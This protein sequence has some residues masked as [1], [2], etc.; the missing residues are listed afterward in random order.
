MESNVSNGSEVLDKLANQN[1][2]SLSLLELVVNLIFAFVG[3]STTCLNALVII[4]FVKE[5]RIREAPG[6]VFILNLAISDSLTGIFVCYVAILNLCK[7]QNDEEYLFRMGFVGAF[8]LA[9]S[10]FLN[11]LTV[12]RYLKVTMHLRYLDLVTTRKHVILCAVTWMICIILGMLPLFGWHNPVVKSLSFFETF[13]QSYI[14][15]IFSL[16]ILPAFCMIYAYTRLYFV[17]RQHRRQIACLRQPKEGAIQVRKTRAI[18]R[19]I[20]LLIGAYLTCWLP[21][22]KFFPSVLLHTNA[23]V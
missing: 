23:S 21:I 5:Q 18:I 9:S 10:F 16:G 22:G 1:L 6:N 8:L 12:D 3:T 13:T 20:F 17:S 19:S 4:G 14:I 2:T 15:G 11:F 7:Y